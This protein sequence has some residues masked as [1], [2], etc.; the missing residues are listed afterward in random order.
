M[1]ARQAFAHLTD[2]LPD[3]LRRLDTLTSQVSARHAEFTRLSTPPSGAADQ[4]LKRKKT[5]S[6]ESLRPTD[7]RPTSPPVER[8]ESNPTTPQSPQRQIDINPDSRHLFRDFQ[9]E[10]RRRRGAGSIGSAVSGPRFRSRMSMI[11]YYDSAIQEGF[12]WL[13]RNISGARSNLRKGKTAASFKARMG[14]MPA[15]ASPFVGN[16]GGPISLRNPN[17]PRLGGSGG[18]STYVFDQLD[19]LL[20][21]AQS[22]CEVNLPF[23]F[24]RLDDPEC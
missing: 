8:G 14:A 11:V 10:S 7:E 19:A 18:A 17:I 5:G 12:E 6:T 1:D 13:V 4:Q 24:H 22:L 2:N 3:W 9:M 23:P 16:G 21:A 15:E 20:E